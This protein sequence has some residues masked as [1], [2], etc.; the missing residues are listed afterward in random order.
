MVAGAAELGLARGKLHNPLWR[1]AIAARPRR[2]RRRVPRPRAERL[3]LPAL[4]VPAPPARLDARSSARSSR[5]A[6]VVRPR[7]VAFAT[8]VRAAFVALAVM[9]YSDRDVAPVFG[10][11]SPLAGAAAPMRA[12]RPRRRRR[13]RWLLPAAAFAHATLDPTQPAFRQRLETRAGGGLRCTSTRASTRCRTRSSSTTR[14]GKIVSAGTAAMPPMRARSSSPSAPAAARRLHRPLARALERRPRRLRRV[15]VRR[16]RR[17]RR[18]RRRRTAHP[19]PTRTEHVVR[20]AYFAR[21]RAPRRRARLPAARA[22]PGDPAP[23]LERRFYIVTGIGVIAV[24]QVGIVAFILRA[25]DALQ[26]PFGRLLY[27]DLSPVASGT[28]FGQAFIAMTLGFTLVVAALLFLAWLKGL[29]MAALAR[30]RARRRARGRPLA[31]GS[32]RR[33]GSS[34]SPSWRTGCTCRPPCL[35]LGGLVQLAA[36]VWPARAGAAPGSVPALRPAGA[37]A[38]RRARRRRRVSEHPPAAA[39]ERPL[40]AA[41]TARCCWSSSALVSLAL[42]WGGFHHFVVR[43]RLERTGWAGRSLVGEGAVAMTILLLAAILVNA[44]PPA[45]QPATRTSLVSNPS[46]LPSNAP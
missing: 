10:H 11:L 6:G 13:S 9:L 8:R 45:A 32:R 42:A 20:W 46:S 5:S 22:C 39:A 27:G 34:W 41:R 37:R 43:P 15:H 21:A 33:C 36:L 2:L 24:V 7:S 23:A 38:H 44:K 29:R 1:L 28:R 16:P 17:R 26:L 35:W 40:D 3:V 4:G 12:A 25:E 14:S 31:L 30:V 18:R 19:G